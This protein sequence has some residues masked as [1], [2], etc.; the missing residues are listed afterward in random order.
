[1]SQFDIVCVARSGSG[2]HGHITAVGVKGHRKG[3][4]TITLPVK[5]VRQMIRWSDVE[6]YSTDDEGDRARVWRYSCRDCGTKTIRTSPDD[7]S[8]DNLSKK[9][10]CA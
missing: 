2:A 3:S 5:A 9:P 8:D 7:I 1:M 4:P 6:F 10:V